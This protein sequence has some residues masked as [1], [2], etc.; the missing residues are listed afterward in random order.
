MFIGQNAV[1]KKFGEWISCAFR[2]AQVCTAQQSLSFTSAC[3][4]QLL[5][6]V[7]QWIIKWVV[8]PSVHYS[9]EISMAT[10]IPA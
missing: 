5:I 4:V 10:V 9:K 8:V 3:T 2:T 1:R 7:A 6:P